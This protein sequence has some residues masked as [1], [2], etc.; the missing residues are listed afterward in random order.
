MTDA[1][2]SDVAID[3]Y[4]RH[5]A[6][7]RGLSNNT[8]SAYAVDLA[9]LSTFLGERGVSATRSDAG[10]LITFLG[11]QA[12]EGLSAR[13]QARRWVA[14]RGLFRGCGARG[15]SRAI[16]PRGSPCPSSGAGCPRF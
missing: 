9:R 3:D 6:V 15:S 1:P 8:L 4:L 2:D 11:A 13:L 7:E 10:V 12:K 16:R 14:V 5:L